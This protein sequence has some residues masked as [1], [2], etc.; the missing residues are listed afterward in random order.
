MS[1]RNKKI[2]IWPILFLYY[3]QKS[4]I[5]KFEFKTIQVSLCQNQYTY[6]GLTT[7]NYQYYCRASFLLQK[8][9]VKLCQIVFVSALTIY[10]S[11]STAYT[12]I[13]SLLSQHLFLEGTKLEFLYQTTSIVVSMQIN[14]L[15][16]Y[17]VWKKCYISLPKVWKQ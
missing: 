16:I 2:S 8:E 4:G 13:F 7:L 14:F 17:N 1:G 6:H 11:N 9:C 12:D 5:I 15:F 3:E 10:S